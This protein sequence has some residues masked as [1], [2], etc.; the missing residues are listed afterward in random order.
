MEELI[1]VG[2][3][4]ANGLLAHRLAVLRPALRFRLL[5]AGPTLGGNHTW[6][7]H[8]SDVTDD[9][10]KWLTPLCAGS[11]TGHH[12]LFPASARVLGG[13]YHSIRSG[14]F[15]RL[16]MQQL[17]DRVRLNT[18]VAEVAA[19]SVRLASGERLEAR[20]VI[21]GRGRFVS[22]AAGFQKFLG[23]D[24]ILEAPHGLTRPVLMDASVE[25]LDGF[26]FVYA[27]PWDARRVLIEDTTYSDSPA[28]DPAALRQRIADWA[29]ARGWSIA[30]VEREE[31]AAL[32]IPL[33]GQAP[34][35]TLPTL[36][37]SA[38]FFHATTGYSLPWAASLAD[39]LASLPTLDP[40][41]LTARLNRLAQSHWRSQGFYRLLNRMLFGAL[42]PNERV[43]IFSAFYEHPEA[44]V[45]RFYA[46]R[47]TLA[48]KLAVFRRGAGS[49]PTL[50]ALGAAVG[51]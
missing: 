17:G 28:L 9:Q 23:Q 19:D 40:A 30:A 44:L 3:G 39:T 43:R 37:V 48:D 51:R 41:S 1:L 16:L 38:G 8:G 2:G 36:G 45:A 42:P 24:L 12:I 13:S 29:R 5:E 46:G 31:L 35:L 4:L 20:T 15:H 21:D 7:F 10:R 11:W 34:R 33:G 47:L 22:P 14:D 50:K 25:Q 32:P 49:V 18:P 27:L 6:S 26:R